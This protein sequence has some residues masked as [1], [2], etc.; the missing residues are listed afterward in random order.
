MTERIVRAAGAV[1]W[2]RNSE[3]V[4]VAVVHRPRYDDWSLPKGKLDRGETLP[5]A[6][7]REVAEETGFSCVLGHFLVETRYPVTHRRAPATKTVQYFAARATGGRFQQSDEVDRLRWLP[8][9]DAADVLT[10]RAD[11]AVLE[12]FVASGTEVTTVLLVRHAKAGKR[13]NWAGDDDLRP[14]SDAGCKQTD[15]LTA[16]LPLFGADRVH[17]AP[18]VRCVQTVRP[19][20][21]WLG[22]TIVHEPAL[23]E[24]GFADDPTAAADRIAAIAAAGGTPV[25]CSQGAV[26]PDVIGDLAGRAGIAMDDVPAK[27]GSL[28]LLAFRPH[29]AG[30]VR[31][32]L[33]I[34][35]HYVASPLPPPR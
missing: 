35:A 15:A 20:A 19:T 33:L 3:S 22:A 23:S 6:A 25:I 14:L 27:K 16:M 8:V 34:G 7:V 10:Y 26:I 9:S 31:P 2:R 17:A 29:G 21:E 28:W 12:Q 30:H 24:E 32:P 4:E 18:R 11:R 13:E 5:A 1:L